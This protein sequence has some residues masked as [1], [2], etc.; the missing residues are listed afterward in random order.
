[1][2]MTMLEAALDY[3]ERGWSVIPID[4]GTKKPLIKWHDFQESPP[5]EEH[6][7]SWWEQWTNADIAVLTGAATG[8]VVVDC[9][10]QDA[11]HAAFDLGMRSPIRVKTKRGYHL[12]FLHP[13]DGVRR[14]PRAGSTT[15]GED[16]PKV[17]GLDFRGDGGY[18]LL[19]PSKGYSWDYPAGLDWDDAPIWQDW[20]PAPMPV[21][22][23]EFEFSAL[24][25]SA[26]KEYTEEDYLSEWERTALYVQK[27]FPS[28]KKIPTGMSNGRNERVMRHISECVMDGFFGDELRLRGIAF[29]REFFVEPLDDREF[30]ATVGSIEEAERRNHPERFD[31]DGRYIPRAMTAP[32]T[33]AVTTESEEAERV[34]SKR[35]LI[36]MA[37][38]EELQKQADSKTFLIEPWL[39]PQTIIQ[40][41][42]Y[43]GHGKSL[44]LQHALGALTAGR[45]YF[46]PFEVGRPA[47]VLY[48]DYENGMATLARRL[49]ELKSAHGDAAD[50]LGVWTPFLE[51]VDLNLNTTEGMLGLQQWIEFAQ[52]EVVVIDTLR[53]AFPGLKENSAEEWGKINQLAVRIRNAGMAVIMVHHGN[54]PGENGLG[55]EAGSTNQLTVLETQIRV[56]QVYED[57]ETAKM[58]AAIWD[59]SYDWPVWPLLRKKCPEGFRLYMVNEIRYGKVREWSDVH[60]PVQWIGYAAHDETDERIIVASE[61]SKQKAKSMYLNGLPPEE[62]A[63]LLHRPTKLVREWLAAPDRE[64]S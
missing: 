4:P 36:T 8:I 60:D 46:G 28:T 22:S 31:A 24:D 10:N 64:G 37:D 44:F 32:V 57:E 21:T 38:A 49:E 40:V 12:Y 34:A 43:S 62:I 16:W 45:K 53:S 19:P 29:M 56:G 51:G 55:G 6:I 7:Y 13:R 17:P 59:G 5:T 48:M 2:A 47:R 58:K 61:S 26:V 23:G 63:S 41:Y 11:W 54:K 52:P 20:K 3:Y 15:R 30:E 14:G 50:R 9:D 18:A 1:M 27:N 35:K 33:G 42:G 39:P 25:L